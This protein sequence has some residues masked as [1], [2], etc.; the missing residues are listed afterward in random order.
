MGPR[1]FSRSAIDYLARGRYSVVLWNCTPR[2]WEGDEGW[3]DRCVAD[4]QTREWS[5]VLMHDLP[6]GAMRF[7][8]PLLERLR[9]IGADFVQ[10]FPAECVPMERGRMRSDL[11]PFTSVR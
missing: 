3:V 1:L 6:T 5:V 4:V 2:D 9:S 10:T 11:G 7:L 8:E